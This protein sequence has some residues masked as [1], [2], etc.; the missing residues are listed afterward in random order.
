MAAMP[1]TSGLTAGAT[2][3][4]SQTPLSALLTGKDNAGDAPPAYL[5]YLFFDKDMHYRYGGFVQMSK[6]ALEDGSDV[7]HEKLSSEVIVTEPGF[8]Y[9]YLSNESTTP[10]EV[11][12]DNF[13]VS[14]S[15]SQLVQL[16]DYYP[17]GM[18]ASHWVR[19]GEQ[20]TRDL[21]QG[22]TYEQLTQLADFGARHYDAVLGRWHA[23]DP[24]DQF[25]LPYTNVLR[26]AHQLQIN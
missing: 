24:A 11:F 3:G 15:E 9:I 21:F 13:T 2:T 14:V 18:V 1:A 25:A 10:S 12:F 5:N 8:L 4:A 20:V 22:K 26:L 19:T 16:I 17:Y 7:P 23:V 6:A